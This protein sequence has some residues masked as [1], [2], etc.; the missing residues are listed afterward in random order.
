MRKACA[1]LFFILRARYR[2]SLLI[3]ASISLI[4][5]GILFGGLWSVITFF[6]NRE[7]SIQIELQ[8]Q[9]II[10]A[11]ARYAFYHGYLP[12]PA[13]T[14]E[15]TTNNPNDWVMMK[16]VGPV[17]WKELG[18]RKKPG[19]AGKEFV[20]VVSP[21][22]IRRPY[23]WHYSPAER[24]IEQSPVFWRDMH[25]ATF[26][27]PR[28]CGLVNGIWWGMDPGDTSATLKE[29]VA[30]SPESYKYV[31]RRKSRGSYSDEPHK[32]FLLKP[33]PAYLISCFSSLLHDL[34]ELECKIGGLFFADIH[35]EDKL[36]PMGR[37]IGGVC[38][39]DMDLYSLKKARFYGQAFN[40]LWMNE[41]VLA[42]CHELPVNRLEVDEKAEVFTRYQ[43]LSI[44]GYSVSGIFTHPGYKWELSNNVYKVIQECVI[45]DAT[46]G[47]AR[48]FD[49]DCVFFRYKSRNM[50]DFG[51]GLSYMMTGESADKREA[52]IRHT[53]GLGLRDQSIMHLAGASGPMLLS[54][55]M[56]EAGK[57]I[58]LVD[59]ISVLRLGGRGEFV[60]ASEYD[61]V[62]ELKVF[63][64][65]IAQL[66][67]ILKPL[68][69]E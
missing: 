42:I 37:F 59:A 25:H 65:R 55:Y 24:S 66:I 12:V 49:H 30:L 3:E 11:A 54:C 14:A 47:E 69:C 34:Y 68:D 36:A 40:A 4:V 35:Y 62:Q 21:T 29:Y 50:Q 56:W 10:E 57:P 17:P 38:S 43:L 26:G 32:L 2:G 18:L 31:I 7:Q 13:G 9:E 28:W 19:V 67:K 20:W 15:A 1:R 45:Q 23:P 46:Q 8:K 58:Y 41:P 51:P 63:E 33:N 61:S 60:V 27:R 39:G 48:A 64:E 53:L 16:L 6:K 5:F 22:A 44:A 52:L